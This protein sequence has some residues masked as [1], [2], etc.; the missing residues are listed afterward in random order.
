MAVSPMKNV[1]QVIEYAITR[2]PADKILLGMN[3]Y[4]YDWRCHGRKDSERKH[5]L[6]QQAA[7]L[8]ERYGA[9]IIL[10]RKQE[11]HILNIRMKRGTIT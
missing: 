9:Q 11:R 2:I 3:N 6:I 4:G 1:R 5:S 10:I 7:D 8:A